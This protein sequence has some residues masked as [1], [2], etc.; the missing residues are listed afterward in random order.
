MSS[1]LPVVPNHHADYPPFQGV[2]GALAGL[3]MLIANRDRVSLA[4]EL[5][6]LSGTD[7]VV[8]VGC[9]PGTAAR[10]GARCGAQIIGVDPAPSM[11]SIARRVTRRTDAIVWRQGTAESL[12]V[13]DSWATVVWSIATVH[14][15]N[16]VD[17]G[18]AEVR[19]VLGS[20]GRLVVVERQVRPGASGHASHGWTNDQADAFAHRCTQA[21]FVDPAVTQ[22]RSGRSSLVAVTASTANS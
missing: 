19:R 7:R 6:T 12:P 10:A 13:P 11:L 16:D 22:H 8:D 18:L 14:H 15:W 20:R 1:P 5:S 4:I 9:G 3:S 21:G 17:R 2:G